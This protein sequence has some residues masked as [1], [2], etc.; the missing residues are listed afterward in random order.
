[1]L[2]PWSRWKCGRALFS[3]WHENY[4]TIVTST[5]PFRGLFEM[6]QA[7]DYDAV[8]SIEKAGATKALGQAEDFVD[9]VITYSRKHHPQ[10]F[11]HM[12]RQ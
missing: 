9:Q 11:R 10:L 3:R 4:S 1:M 7:A 5:T 2:G 12:D 6:R 8:S